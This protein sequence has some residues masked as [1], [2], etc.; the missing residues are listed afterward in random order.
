MVDKGDYEMDSK[1]QIDGMKWV[2]K[3][4]CF[5]FTSVSMF[6]ICCFVTMGAD[7][8][9]SMR[10][11][12]GMIKEC[13]EKTIVFYHTWSSRV[14]IN[15][16]IFILTSKAKVFWAVYMG[17]SLFALQKAFSIL[18][19]DSVDD[20][21]KYNI[22]ISVFVFA[23]S[24]SEM[25]SAGWIATSCTYLGPIA[26]GFVALI[27]IKKLL[28]SEKLMWWEYFVYAIC[29]CYGANN[30][31]MLIVILA[32]YLIALVYGVLSRRR[33]KFLVVMTLMSIASLAFILTC[34]GNHNRAGVELVVH[35]P[36]YG[37]LNFLN[38][39]DLGLT[40]AERYFLFENRIIILACVMFSVLVFEKYKDLMC[41][42]ISCIP[43]VCIVSL[44][45]LND[46]V[47]KVYPSLEALTREIP[48][49]GLVNTQ[50]AGG[51]GEGIRYAN[52]LL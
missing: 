1:E 50:N 45:V 28:K 20:K 46:I 39:F 25:S 22:L 32:S 24:F 3:N 48:N 23:Y 41:R 15:F 52:I 38:K 26:C 11:Q 9:G 21:E 47:I 17:C 5:L 6:L 16:V 13:W 8:I 49:N 29:L 18:F 31:Q 14:L 2:Q 33:S 4:K 27:P 10:V 42:V 12:D 36:T 43:I 40:A 35:N 34:P 44:S 7:D 30:E 37:M 19:L 51:G